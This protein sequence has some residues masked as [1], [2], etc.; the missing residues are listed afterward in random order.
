RMTV[1][2]ETAEV[3]EGDCVFIEKNQEHSLD[4]NGSEDLRLMFV[5]APKIV[6]DHWAREKSGELGRAAHP[7]DRH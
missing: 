6:V 3:G 5:Y 1:A 4:N 2:D 7:R